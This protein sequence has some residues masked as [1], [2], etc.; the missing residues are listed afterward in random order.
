MQCYFLQYNTDLQLKV[1]ALNVLSANYYLF[2]DTDQ[3]L[4]LMFKAM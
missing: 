2:G 3:V 1:T 4:S